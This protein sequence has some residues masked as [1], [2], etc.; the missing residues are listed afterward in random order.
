MNITAP[1]PAP[2]KHTILSK[3]LVRTLSQGRAKYQANNDQNMGSRHAGCWGKTDWAA[4]LHL[5][6]YLPWASP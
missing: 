4:S 2:I 6:I 3:P 1:Y 5:D